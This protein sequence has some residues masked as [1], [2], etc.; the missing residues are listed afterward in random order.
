MLTS[1]SS[2][3]MSAANL[4]SSNPLLRGGKGF[5]S[6]TFLEAGETRCNSLEKP[7]EREAVRSWYTGDAE[8]LDARVCEVSE[9]EP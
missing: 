9:C 5:C 3:I 7:E 6:S 1:A 4:C 2:S 8:P